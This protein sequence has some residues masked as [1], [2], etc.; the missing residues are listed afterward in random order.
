MYTCIVIQKAEI[1]VFRESG[2]LNIV[3][4]SVLQADYHQASIFPETVHVLFNV[5]DFCVSSWDKVIIHKILIVGC[6]L[7]NSIH[8]K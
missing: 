6:C 3:P 8:K 1:M 4:Q 7:Y 2:M 5:F